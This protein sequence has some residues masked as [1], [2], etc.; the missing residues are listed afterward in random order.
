MVYLPSPYLA[1]LRFSV[2]SSL[3]PNPW[4]CPVKAATWF[5][6]R[7]HCAS[8]IGRGLWCTVKFLTLCFL[9]YLW[10]IKPTL[11]QLDVCV[12]SLF[13]S[14]TLRPQYYL[15]KSYKLHLSST[16]LKLM[17]MPRSSTKSLSLPI[18]DKPCSLSNICLIVFKYCRSC[19]DV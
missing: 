5:C 17:V 13:P 4:E 15:Y 8:S 2:R 3:V 18:P 16:V 1:L 19:F 11:S 12:D 14:N 7:S 6:S 10:G 9:R